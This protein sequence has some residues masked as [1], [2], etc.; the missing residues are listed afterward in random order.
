MILPH[1][2]PFGEGNDDASLFL[3]PLILSRSDM[4]SDATLSDPQ[5]S[6]TLPYAI[7]RLVILCF[8]CNVIML[9]PEIPKWS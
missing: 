8:P 9:H 4:L 2:G 6:W 5:P 1:W 3:F 7:S